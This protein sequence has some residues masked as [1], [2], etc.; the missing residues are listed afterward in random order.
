M[1]SFS[2]FEIVHLIDTMQVIMDMSEV[3]LAGQ[4]YTKVTEFAKA[5]G[6]TGL[7][8][9][10]SLIAKGVDE[11]GRLIFDD[12]EGMPHD[13]A[14]ELRDQYSENVGTILVT[15]TDEQAFAAMADDR[16]DFIIPF[17]R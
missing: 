16:I 14:F 5:F 6:N 10:L 7:K 9:N 3:G 17:H 2:D 13:T 12:R 8:I 15:F 4:A 11:N 1:Q